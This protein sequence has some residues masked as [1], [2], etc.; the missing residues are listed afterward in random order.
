MTS[1][2][3]P[4]YLPDNI[5]DL[6][7]QL[8][9]ATAKSTDPANKISLTSSRISFVLAAMKMK[10]RERIPKGLYETLYDTLRKMINEMLYDD[11]NASV[12]LI[13]KELER[14]INENST[15]MATYGTIEAMECLSDYN[16]ILSCRERWKAA[17]D[18][19]M[20]DHEAWSMSNKMLAD[21]HDVLTRIEIRHNLIVVPKNVSWDI[22]DFNFRKPTQ[23]SGE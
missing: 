20:K 18:I 5:K 7:G 23:E 19:Y 21:I 9:I 16:D 15:T 3:K 22:N 11:N 13:L 6:I 12:L 2:I 14:I 17:N 10:C 8:A 4:V 1:D